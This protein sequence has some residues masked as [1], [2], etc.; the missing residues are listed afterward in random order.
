[1]ATVN[2]TALAPV[3]VSLAP[4][5]PGIFT[6]TS[7]GSGQ[8]IVIDDGPVAQAGAF[9]AATNSIPGVQA[10]PAAPGDF[11]TIYCT[12]LGSVTS[13][14]PTG[15]AGA[16]QS[17]TAVPVVSIGGLPATVT[18]AG[19]APTLV[20]TYQ[21]NVQVP[22]NAPAGDAVPVILALDG[23]TSNAVTVALQS[24]NSGSGS[25]G[26]ITVDANA[27]GP[28]ISSDAFGINMCVACDISNPASQSAML[29]SVGVNLVRWP[30]GTFSDQYH[31]QTNAWSGTSATCGSVYPPP[32]ADAFDT[33]ESTLVIPEQLT[34]I[35][36]RGT[37]KKPPFMA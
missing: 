12:G 2:G 24:N 17:T 26:V 29:K 19:L 22:A 34:A 10:Q 35:S 5:A 36:H 32:S 28:V 6:S 31:W 23:A 8:G 33:M 4:A 15:S 25:S 20:G 37:G 14:P 13:P 16:G 18:F 30:G 1:V 27:L 11:I 21:I 7:Q 9:A 3:T